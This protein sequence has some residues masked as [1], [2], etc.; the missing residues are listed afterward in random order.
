LKEIVEVLDRV[1]FDGGTLA[2]AGIADEY[3]Q[4]VAND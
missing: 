1:I 2:H 4:P 3:V